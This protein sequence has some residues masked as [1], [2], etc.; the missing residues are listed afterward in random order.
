MKLTKSIFVSALTIIGAAAIVSSCSDRP[1][2]EGTWQGN[3]ERIQVAGASEAFS[4][5]SIDFAPSAEKNAPGLV[6]LSAVVEV[7]APAAA[8]ADTGAVQPW[9]ANVTATA[10]VSGTYV[11]EEHEDDDIILSLDPSTLLVRV[12]PAGVVSTFNVLDGTDSAALDSLTQAA[13]AQWS[14]AIGR[15]VMEQFNK[16]NRIEDIKVHHGD[17][18]TAEIADRDLTFRR[19]AAQ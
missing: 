19:T 8:S 9:Q 4:T 2:L 10:S 15:G 6:N 14:Q 17:M 12:D 11:F 1:D 5:V 7:H 18:L 13:V 16:Y 3:Q